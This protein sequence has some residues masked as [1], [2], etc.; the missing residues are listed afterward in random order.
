MGNK[1]ACYKIRQVIELTGV[2]E[3]LLRVW[4][5]RYLAFAPSRT[6][7]GRRLY[8]ENDILKAR[9]LLA[10]TQKGVRI[11]DIAQLSLTKLNRL[12]H[13]NAVAEIEKKANP[14][15]H[16][17]IKSANQFDWEK[18]R[19]LVLTGKK[20]RKHLDWIHSLIVPLLIEMGRQVDNGHFT[21]A[22]E[23]ILSAIIKENL[24]FHPYRRPPLKNRPRI[25][26][27]TPEG[28]HHDLGLMVAAYIA[29]ELRVNTLFLGPH[30]PMDELASVC[31]RSQATHL[32]LSSTANKEDGAKDDYLSYLNFL[33]R[34]LNSE[35]TIWLAGRN[36]QK[37][38][39]SLER[40][41]KLIHSFESFETEVKKCL[42]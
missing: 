24:A 12:L 3:F 8:S 18:V 39:I 17:I 15:V 31:V 41:F 7:T 6:R 26:F 28:D 2:S 33:D 36:S 21:I 1:A 34:N 42:K 14:K 4:E 20:T 9:S 40:P 25:V 38:S 10:L 37:Y 32:V 23:H 5:D 19:T 11:G 16:E 30:M 27:T 22:Q 13:Q 29:T 35:L